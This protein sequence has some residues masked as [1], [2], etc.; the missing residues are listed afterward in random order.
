MKAEQ[1]QI[2]LTQRL[3]GIRPEEAPTVAWSF[4]YVSVLFLA[5]YVLRPI[6]DELGVASG[7]SNLPWLFSGALLAMITLNPLFGHLVG[8]YSRQSVIAI[9]YRS[10]SATLAAIAI[11][12]AMGSNAY[13]LWIGRVFFI[14]VSIFNL[15]V[16]SVFWSFIQD[17]FDSDQG[18]RLFGLLSA[19]ATIGGLIGAA[20]TTGLIKYIDR[21]WLLVVAVALIEVAVIASRRA[22][23][24]STQYMNDLNRETA[25]KPVGGSAFSGI[26]RI[27]Q[28]SYLLGM[29][30]FILIY[31]ITSAFLYF[32]QASYAEVQLATSQA[33][34]E[35]FGKIDLWV[36]ATTLLVQIFLTGRLLAKGGILVTLCALPLVSVAGFVALAAH[37]ST[38]VFVIVQVLRRVTNFAITRPAREVLF[39]SNTRD[40]RYKA[41]NFIDTVVYRGGDQ[42]GSWSYA[43]LMCVGLGMGQIAIVGIPIS[44]AWLVLS[45]WLGRV[46]KRREQSEATG[47]P[48]Q[49]LTTEQS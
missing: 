33:R 37:P 26:S 21:T 48:S 18:K 1:H 32:Q 39:T 2:P 9:S 3:L 8:R 19:G 30:G 4:L 5:Y 29:S 35:F 28:S 40:E 34:T 38:C 14:W 36:H 15:F 11:L 41:K 6:R 16:V 46:H 22:S 43:S 25:H 12:F 45:F 13:H 31:S 24:S 10:F 7:V 27:F 47:E 49:Y 44:V 23:R 20:L 17:I 42:L